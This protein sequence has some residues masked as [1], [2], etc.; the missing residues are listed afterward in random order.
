MLTMFSL[1][2]AGDLEEKR[3][4]LRL[5]YRHEVARNPPASFGS[6]CRGWR[7]TSRYLGRYLFNSAHGTVL[8]HVL[9]KPI[10]T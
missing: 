10:S 5:R 7:W 2:A 8:G 4:R 1:Y 3:L 9:L 6:L